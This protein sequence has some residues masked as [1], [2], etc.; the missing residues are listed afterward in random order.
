MKAAELID[1]GPA[2]NFRIVDL[3]V[4]EPGPWE[5]LMKVE[6]AGLRWGDIMG[7]NGIPVRRRTPPFV[8]GQEAAGTVV[9]N[10]EGASRFAP[11]IASTACRRATRTRSTSPYRSARSGRSLTAFRSSKRSSTP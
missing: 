4:P 7:R 3:P 9:K 5:T 1:Y 11:A 8:P 2:E 6:Y 10:G